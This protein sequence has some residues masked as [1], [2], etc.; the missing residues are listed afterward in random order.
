MPPAASP[1]VEKTPPKARM[2]G[3]S[4]AKLNVFS[5]K[6]GGRTTT[7]FA[8]GSA[9]A[10]GG[11]PPPPPPPP[12]P[13]PESLERAA[14]NMAAASFI[15]RSWSGGGVSSEEAPSEAPRLLAL[16]LALPLAAPLAASWAFGLPVD[17]SAGPPPLLDVASRA[18][19]DA[20]LS[21]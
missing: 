19:V 10:P 6:E 17:A 3:D 20:C 5:Q 14:L 8:P 1:A 2:N 21:S 11:E 15:R 12:P 16:A 4:D 13:S 9:S 18:A 7:A